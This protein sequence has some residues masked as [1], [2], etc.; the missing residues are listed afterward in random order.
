MQIPT[1][2]SHKELTGKLNQALEGVATQQDI[3]IINPSS[4]AVDALHLGYSIKSDLRAVLKAILQEI[5]PED[6][7]GDR[8]PQ[9]SYENEILGIELFAFSWASPLFGR[10]MYFKFAFDKEGKMWLVSLHED[11]RRDN[12]TKHQR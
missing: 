1:R 2:P 10:K 9:K 12:R 8:P 6:Y 3:P 5:S 4:F 7:A 11:R